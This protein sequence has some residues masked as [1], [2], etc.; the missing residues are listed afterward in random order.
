MFIKHGSKLNP[1]VVEV[2]C[3]ICQENRAVSPH[4]LI[5]IS[6]EFS[7][8]KTILLCKGCHK[9]L[10]WS[11]PNER[12]AK[13]FNTKKKLRKAELS[14]IPISRYWKEP[15]YKND[16]LLKRKKCIVILSGKSLIYK[17]YYY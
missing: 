15:D 7:S 9:A 10:H 8:K 14:Q 12:L 4:H 2:V 3:P 1:L 16:P 13:E 6:I 17:W 11:Y 5:P